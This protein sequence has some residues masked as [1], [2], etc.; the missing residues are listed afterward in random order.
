MTTTRII[1]RRRVTF[2]PQECAACAYRSLRNNL[3]SF[4]AKTRCHRDEIFQLL[5]SFIEV[6]ARRPRLVL[7]RVDLQRRLAILNSS[8]FVGV[9]ILN[10]D[11]GLLLYS[12]L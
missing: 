10:C 4:P 9:D 1:R 8:P 11:R 6:K 3:P 7:G 2:D 5:G 12:T